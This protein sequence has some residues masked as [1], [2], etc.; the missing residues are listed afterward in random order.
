[1]GTTIVVMEPGSDW[2]GPFG[3]SAHVLAFGV[4]ADNRYDRTHERLAAM[5]GGRRD[6]S[7]AVLACNASTGAIAAVERIRL[8]RSM[9]DALKDVAHGRLVL[10]ASAGSSHELLGDLLELAAT[11]VDGARGSSATVSL[12]FSAG[13]GQA[14]K[15]AQRA[16]DDRGESA[17]LA[18]S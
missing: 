7:V 15:P 2:P 3:K 8:G 16:A 11:L 18:G 10:S 1:M 17:S 14:P 6:V 9:L 5:F 4:G 13:P 12:N